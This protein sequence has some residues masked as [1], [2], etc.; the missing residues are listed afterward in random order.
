[1]PQTPTP[2]LPVLRHPCACGEADP[3]QFDLRRRTSGVLVYVCRAMQ[4][5]SAAISKCALQ[6]AH[7]PG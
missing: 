3:A 2:N 6:L 1:M 5:L 7:T 4:S